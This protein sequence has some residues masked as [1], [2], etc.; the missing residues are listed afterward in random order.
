MIDLSENLSNSVIKDI[1]M[2]IKREQD[3][4]STVVQEKDTDQKVELN[5][6]RSENVIQGK[7]YDMVNESSR[8]TQMQSLQRMAD[9]RVGTN[10]FEPIQRKGNNT[11]LPNNIKSGIE[12]LSGYSMGDV[13]VHYN[14]NKPAQLQAHAYAQGTDIHI[15]SGQEKHLPHEAWHVVQQKQGRVKPTMQMKGDVKVNDDEGLE[16]EADVMGTKALSSKTA[17]NQLQSNENEGLNSGV[18]QCKM[19]K[20]P[21]NSSSGIIQ[22]ESR[23]DKIA[24]I[25]RAQKGTDLG[26]SKTALIGKESGGIFTAEGARKEQKRDRIKA[27]QKGTDLGTSSSTLIGKEHGGPFYSEKIAGKLQAHDKRVSEQTSEYDVNPALKGKLHVAP[28]AFD[29]AGHGSQKITNE[30]YSTYAKSKGLS[31]RE[32]EHYMSGLTLMEDDYAIRMEVE[33]AE[34]SVPGHRGH[35]GGYFVSKYT[36]TERSAF[37]ST[38]GTGAVGTSEQMFHPGKHNPYQ[39]D[40][41]LK[42]RLT[43]AVPADSPTGAYT[44][45]SSKF[46][47]DKIS[48]EALNE[49][50]KRATQEL[51]TNP[52]AYEASSGVFYKN[53]SVK[54][55]LGKDTGS[56]FEAPSSSGT[57]TGIRDLYGNSSAYEGAKKEALKYLDATNSEFVAK[58]VKTSIER[59]RTRP[60]V[61]ANI[62]SALG[63]KSVV[64]SAS[65]ANKIAKAGETKVYSDSVITSIPSGAATGTQTGL[66]LKSIKADGSNAVWELGAGQHYPAQTS[67]GD[68]VMRK[69]GGATIAGT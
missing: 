38:T 11:N 43:D 9:S 68:F 15:A 57:T 66:T 30:E 56:G 2:K 33:R 28:H 60:Q 27:L 45:I 3:N 14:S 50:K 1:L 20:S 59:G 52:S 21:L 40:F 7:L 19:E 6:T 29:I 58:L 65:N 12:N 17:F 4:I 16:R 13:K 22:M 34:E 62:L 5:D 8:V 26:T 25:K 64:I 23:K 32:A 63:A 18:L 54:L 48:M 69:F 47:S 67:T 37:D 35:S 42:H 46:I 53:W 41:N 10:S 49:A 61:K 36:D 31:G 51:R 24:R 44:S 39:S 55:D